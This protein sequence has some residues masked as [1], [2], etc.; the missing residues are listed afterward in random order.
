MPLT[1]RAAAVA[2]AAAQ[3]CPCRPLWTT[4]RS[5]C[6]RS[7]LLAC[8]RAGRLDSSPFFSPAML[9]SSVSPP[10]CCQWGQYFPFFSPTTP[11]LS[12]TRHLRR[13][14]TL[15]RPLLNGFR[16]CRFS[17][18]NP[19]SNPSAK[20]RKNYFLFRPRR[21]KNTSAHPPLG[22]PTASLRAS[23][24]SHLPRPAPDLRRAAA[25]A[26]PSRSGPHA[27]APHAAPTGAPS[28]HA[29]PPLRNHGS[30]AKV[31]QRGGEHERRRRWCERGRRSERWW[32]K[33]KHRLSPAALRGAAR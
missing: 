7:S 2:A 10:L 13:L 18:E 12:P 15:R 22:P 28:Q 16:P 14:R 25:R 31:K 11:P 24:T 19:K 21:L 20:F 9:G 29:R 26:P 30:A 3:L 5:F 4:M 33:Q 17:Q 1:H 23:S 32:L 27:P 8:S 6:G